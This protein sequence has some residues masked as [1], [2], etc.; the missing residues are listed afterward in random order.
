[1][2]SEDDTCDPGTSAYPSRLRRRYPVARIKGGWTQEEDAAL[3]RLIAAHGPG[4]WSGMARLLNTT[5][6]STPDCCRIGK[7]CR[8]RYNHH[9]RPDIRKEAWSPNEEDT[10]V[11]GHRQF[12]N[13]WSE[14]SQLLTG[15]T[16]NAVKNHWNA[17]LRRKDV[18]V[19]ESVLR[20]YQH[21]LA[22]TTAAAKAPSPATANTKDSRAAVSQAQAEQQQQ[23]Q[24]LPHPSS[25]SDPHN[26]VSSR[27][28]SRVQQLLLLAAVAAVNDTPQRA[29]PPLFTHSLSAPPQRAA[30]LPGNKRKLA[31]EASSDL[32]EQDDDRTSSD[33]DNYE[34][35]T[36][37]Q[38]PAPAVHTAPLTLAPRCGT[39]PQ[40]SNTATQLLCDS[41]LAQDSST[42]S[43]LTLPR[44]TPT[45]PCSSLEGSTHGGGFWSSLHTDSQAAAGT[46]HTNVNL[47][48]AALDT[49]VVACALP[50]APPARLPQ[51]RGWKPAGAPLADPPPPLLHNLH[52]QSLAFLPTTATHHGAIDSS[53]TASS[54]RKAITAGTATCTAGG[55]SPSGSEMGHSTGARSGVSH[56]M[57]SHHRPLGEAA[58][59][60]PSTPSSSGPQ[61]QI[62]PALRPHPSSFPLFEQCQL[63]L[64][65]AG[66]LWSGYRQRPTQPQPQPAA[67]PVPV[68]LL[69]PLSNWCAA[70]H[71][72]LPPTLGQ[73]TAPAVLRTGRHMTAELLRGVGGGGGGVRR[74]EHRAENFGAV[75]GRCSRHGSTSRTLPGEARDHGVVEGGGQHGGEPVDLREAADTLAQLMHRSLPRQPF[76]SH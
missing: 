18:R 13:H 47:S 70:T 21:Q 40:H 37:R 11:V 41:R 73:H 10:I 8:E 19:P 48:I 22:E 72:A 53:T 23:Q 38:Q 54:I 16:E 61:H 9:L 24:P 39:L 50:A 71:T 60:Q 49:T 30:T 43:R 17:T 68:P 27:V 3:T 59:P 75:L 42:H 35:A 32:D 7:Q 62:T 52:A 14:I 33:G 2:S 57:T 65:T 67:N 15:R 46:A 36:K 34:A 31:P 29:S 64:P 55:S 6:G 26:G 58:L 51:Q 5:I 45:Y 74:V 69:P 20:V 66:L 28:E 76:V 56:S 4:N 44:P 12:G 63:P 25:G 1:M